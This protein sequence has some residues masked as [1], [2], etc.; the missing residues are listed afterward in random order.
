MSSMF[1]LHWIDF[2]P[3]RRNGEE[4]D[5]KIWSNI[6]EQRREAIALCQ[7]VRTTLAELAKGY[8]KDP[9]KLEDSLRHVYGQQEEVE[10]LAR[11]LT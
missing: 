1:V 10:K 6:F 3:C 7:A 5:A 8:E 4:K 2:N 9:V 11:F